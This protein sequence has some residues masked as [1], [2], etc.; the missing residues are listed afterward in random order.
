MQDANLAMMETVQIASFLKGSRQPNLSKFVFAIFGQSNL[1]WKSFCA[2]VFWI[3]CTYFNSKSL[4]YFRCQEWKYS[5]HFVFLHAVKSSFDWQRHQLIGGRQLQQSAD[6]RVPRVHHLLLDYILLLICLSNVY[7]VENSIV[8]IKL[9]LEASNT[10]N[11]GK[12][13]ENALQ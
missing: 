9:N 2:V 3:F 10:I 12:I 6:W 13:N 8:G 5:L 1:K 7:R 4:L 11:T